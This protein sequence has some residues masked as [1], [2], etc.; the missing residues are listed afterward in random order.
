MSRQGQ[1][2]LQ[3]GNLPH[4]LPIISK[5]RLKCRQKLRRCNN[6]SFKGLTRPRTSKPLLPVGHLP[7]V[8]VAVSAGSLGPVAMVVLLS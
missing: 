3:R 5:A 1:R 4:R 8:V 2:C 7:P 6:P